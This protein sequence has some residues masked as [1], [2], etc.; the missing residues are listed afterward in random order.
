MSHRFTHYA[1]HELENKTPEQL[2][3]LALVDR[4][5]NH[6]QSDAFEVFELERMSTDNL[7]SILDSL[8]RQPPKLV[9]KNKPVRQVEPVKTQTTRTKPEALGEA[10]EVVDGKLYRVWIVS[11]GDFEPVRQVDPFEI[12]TARVTHGAVTY[13]TN[14][15]I[16]WLQFGA[17]PERKKRTKTPKIRAAV[18]FGAQVHYLGYFSTLEAADA[19]KRDAKFKLSLGLPI[20]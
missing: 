19:A 14:H 18:R 11:S 16:H 5:L 3:H 13:R 10:F 8:T 17:W 7:Q 1:E 20:G 9:V 6:P 12:R 4:F 2:A 15:L